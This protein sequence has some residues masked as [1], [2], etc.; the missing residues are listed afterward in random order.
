MKY[1]FIGTGNMGG[2][3]A[4][5]V[6]KKYADQVL[7]YDKAM[8]KAVALAA[9][10][11]ARAVDFAALVKESDYVFIGVKPYL[12]AQVLGEVKENLQGKAPVIVSMAAG[13]SVVELSAM[14]DLPIIR[15]LPNTP[16]MV[17]AGLT[18]AVKNEKVTDEM[19]ATYLDAMALSGD[20][21]W[22]DE[23]VFD[24][25]GTVS[26]CGPA[27]AYMFME[28]LADGGVYCGVPRDQAMLCAAQMLIGAGEMLKNSG[29]HPGALKDAVCSPGG[30]TI[31]GVRTLEENGFRFAATQAVINTW[32]KMTG[33]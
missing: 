4:R 28:A 17:G 29:M 20:T 13:I 25:A 6:A 1:G 8:E 24:G 30:S 19:T 27:F 11:G 5:A 9:E 7:L 31:E 3:L 16:V 23:K 15:I 26:S 21:Q 12:V 22:V 14:I 33:K 2:A 32:K 18:L 10:T